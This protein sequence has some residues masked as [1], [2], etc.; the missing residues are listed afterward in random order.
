MAAVR[1]ADLGLRNELLA[2][3]SSVLKEADPGLRSQQSAAVKQLID[4][5][6]DRDSS[7][8]RIRLGSIATYRAVSFTKEGV[9]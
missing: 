7:A 5:V 8:E 9:R 4:V 1:S 6:G 3:A 2:S